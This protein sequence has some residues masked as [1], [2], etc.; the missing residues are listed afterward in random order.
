[1]QRGS[2][3]RS[4]A[5]F[6]VLYKDSES[7]GLDSGV[8]I[9]LQPPYRSHMKTSTLLKGLAGMLLIGVAL[10]PLTL[11]E[12]P[13]DW[14]AEPRSKKKEKRV[15]VTGSMIPQK[16]EVKSIGT[17]TTSSLRV[18]KRGEIDRTGRFT[19]EGV[20]ALDP[21]VQV[22]SGSPGGSN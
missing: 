2:G 19:T 20:L 22:R 6:A 17:A 12:T 4:V 18:Y 5:S 13:R 1:M 7:V 16:V 14:V 10:P 11:A 21:A 3:V 8:E 15:F 9:V